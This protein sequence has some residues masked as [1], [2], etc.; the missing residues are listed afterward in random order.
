MDT[1]L[2]SVDCSTA[3]CSTEKGNGLYFL[4][5]RSDHGSYWHEITMTGMVSNRLGR[6]IEWFPNGSLV[7]PLFPRPNDLH[8]WVSEHVCVPN[9]EKSL[10]DLSSA[11]K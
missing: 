1:L 7:N 5:S 11:I 10:N 3:S 6:V 8:S 2:L 9:G 4:D